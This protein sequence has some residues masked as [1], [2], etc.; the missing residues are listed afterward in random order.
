MPNYQSYITV[1]VWKFQDTLQYFMLLC[2]VS[3]YEPPSYL[4]ARFII[5]IS[6]PTHPAFVARHS[7][8]E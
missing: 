4:L 3:S 5:F 8:A 2:A 7:S 6:Y 1:S